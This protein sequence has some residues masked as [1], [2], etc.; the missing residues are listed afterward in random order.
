MT[1]DET[2]DRIARVW[3]IS[4]L[5]PGNRALRPDSL[6]IWVNQAAASATDP[7]ADKPDHS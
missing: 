7:R 6:A 5:Y 3:L 2:G 4:F 1:I